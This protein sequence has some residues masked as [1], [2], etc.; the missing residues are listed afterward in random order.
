MG[1]ST[2]YNNITTPELLDQV[3]RQNKDLMDDFLEYL[4][5]VG[6]AETTISQYEADLK[7]F[8]VWNLQNNDN[9][10]FTKITKRE[11]ARF[12]NHCINVW[13]WSPKRVRRVKSVISSMSNYIENILDDEPEYEGY[14]AVIRKIES[15]VDDVVRDKTIFEMD[16]L[17]RL[18]DYLVDNKEFEKACMLSLAIN[19]GRRKS[20]LPRFK[21]DYFKDENVRFGSLYKTPEKVKTKGRGKGK[22]LELYVM[23]ND[24]DPYLNLWLDERKRLG[25]ESEWLFPSKGNPSEPIKPEVLDGWVKSFSQFLNKPFYWHSLR[26]LFCTECLKK[27]LPSSVVQEIV[28]WSSA[29]M[30]NLYDDRDADETLSKYFDENGIKQIDNVSLSDM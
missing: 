16:E 4:Q 24:F 7:I 15:P 8:W 14:R 25:I 5:S 28:G 21:V 29:D 9:K 10:E 26:H 11:F 18:L 27:N 17:Q 19:S 20:E 3:L 22:Y 6:R 12:Q 13:Q 23:K 30:V 1:R 2:V